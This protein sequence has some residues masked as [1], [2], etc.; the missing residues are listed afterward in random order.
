MRRSGMILAAG[1]G[2]AGLTLFQSPSWQSIG[3]VSP[4]GNDREITLERD[5]DP[6]D[7][8]LRFLFTTSDTEDYVLNNNAFEVNDDNCVAF[9]TAAGESSICSDGTNTEWTVT[10]NNVR[11][12]DGGSDYSNFATASGALTFA[13]NARPT[14]EVFIPAG[15]FLANAGSPANA[16]I[17]SANAQG[18]A[19]DGTSDESISA[20]FKVPDGFAAVNA[21]CYIGWSSANTGGSDVVWDVVTVPTAVGEDSGL[22][23]NTDSVTD[24]DST[25]ADDLNEASVTV[26]ASTEWAA[27]DIV[28]VTI[29]RDANNAADTLDGVDASVHYFRCTGTATDV[30]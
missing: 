22:A 29:N 6:S 12:G 25:T 17:G 7:P 4:G 18:W 19:M 9:G 27:D 21:T 30:Q 1:I 8:E 16:L 11:I 15:D 3:F 24:T 2:L 26:A 5:G 23:G 28:Y 14:F 10:A 13:G 20:M